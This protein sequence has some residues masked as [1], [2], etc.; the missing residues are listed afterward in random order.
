MFSTIKKILIRCLDFAPIIGPFL[1]LSWYIKW[2]DIISK[3][4]FKRMSLR[5]YWFLGSAICTLIVN[6]FFF[7]ELLHL[8]WYI[9]FP[10]S[11][12][13]SIIVIPLVA[14]AWY[15]CH[16]V[17]LGIDLFQGLENRLIKKF[18]IIRKL[19]EWE[20]KK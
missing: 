18:S 20:D 15:I 4:R 14:V 11:F 13:E 6:I 5:W 19:K 7:G 8:A 1:M 16:A 2:H 9:V 12:A 3:V 10:F 17:F